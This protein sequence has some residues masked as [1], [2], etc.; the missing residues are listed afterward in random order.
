MDFS[1]C[2]ISSFWPFL[3][4]NAFFRS[5]SSFSMRFW[6]FLFYKR[7]DFVYMV[8]R[9][10][11]F[12]AFGEVW[13]PELTKCPPE[14]SHDYNLAIFRQAFGE[15]LSSN[16]TKCLIKKPCTQKPCTQKPCTQSPIFYYNVFLDFLERGNYSEL[17]SE[18]RRLS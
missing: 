9:T 4:S 15:V 17:L 1:S 10:W 6:N 13:V 8:L 11:F 2:F 14:S 7:L 3:S 12:G 16:L 18:S 5:S